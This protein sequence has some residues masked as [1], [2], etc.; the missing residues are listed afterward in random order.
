M[1][2]LE[3]GLFFSIPRAGGLLHPDVRYAIWFL[4][5]LLD[6]G[7]GA[8]VG[9]AL[10]L[11]AG[12]RRESV[13]PRRFIA[14]LGCG[15]AAGYAAW[16]LQWFRV[17]FPPGFIAPILL[18]AFIAC[19]IFLLLNW[20]GAPD[21]LIRVTRAIERRLLAAEI[22]I[23]AILS[24]G[25]AAYGLHHP[26][27]MAAAED[28]SIA[29]RARRPNIV[30]IVL[31]TVRADHLSCYGYRRLTTPNIDSFARR[32][33]QFENVIAASSWTLPSIASI[34]TGLLPHQ[35]GAN[36][37]HA[38]DAGPLTLAAILRSNGYE[39]A[40]FN[41]NPFYGL[42][43]WRL[44][45]GFDVY[46][47]DSYSLRHNLAVTFLGQ[48]ALRSAYNR[49]IRYNQFD[50]RDA[51]DLNRDIMRW[52]RARDTEDPFFLF[53]N[54]MDAHR[55]YLPPAPWDHRFG[56]IPH[57]LLARITAPLKAGRPARPYTSAQRQE[58][59]DGYD[60]SLA[61][62]DDQVERLVRF[63][64]AQPGGD[65]TEFIVTSDHG[66]GFGEHGTYD[67]GWNLYSEVLRVPLVV[68]GPGVPAGVR[69]TDLVAARRLFPTILDLS[70][71]LRGPVA[72]ASLRADWDHRAG[73]PGPPRGVIS[74]LVTYGP[75]GDPASLSLTTA[76]WHL[77]RNSG[78][79]VKLYDARNDPGEHTDLAGLPGFKQV[80]DKLQVLLEE[81]LA[82]SLL[83]WRDA[84]Y[85]SPL[86]RPGATFVEQIS[87]PGVHLA[88]EGIPAGAV[89]ALFSHTKPSQ[90]GKPS[91][92]EQ[93]LLR[94][95]PYH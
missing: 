88:P 7:G 80:K 34:F 59:I 57:R 4:A 77:L 36:W 82:Q 8:L 92:A 26:P 79:A 25:I 84:D 47:D 86:D 63:L 13:R 17:I 19:G 76:Q 68:W 53:V 94:S 41:A 65:D 32:G 48:S 39:T 2:V 85:L 40:G 15:F 49:L 35:H 45:E 1:G 22:V 9:F 62:L 44:S 72:Q 90:L 74:E 71:G 33:V 51:A 11:I 95:L 5:P 67:H 60:N 23:V 21:Y 64:E 81:Q 24:L 75:A 89:Q 58:M 52:S 46:D 87:R 16:M 56:R 18:F 29:L 91:Q 42:G 43:G 70:L 3:A 28:A 78:G 73:S 55:P 50:H 83:P 27:A 37:G 61:Y 6:L 14:A 31:D 38:L 66:E 12:T 93:D 69:V 54:Y 30:L 10:G 20:R